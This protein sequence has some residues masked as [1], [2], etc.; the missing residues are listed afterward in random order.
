MRYL[1]Y[2]WD[3]LWLGITLICVIGALTL[4]LAYLLNG[5]YQGESGSYQTATSPSFVQQQQVNTVN[6]TAIVCG[7]PCSCAPVVRTIPRGETVTILETA[8]CSGDTWYRINV[9]EWI[10]PNLIETGNIH[11]TG[12]AAAKVEIIRPTPTNRPPTPTSEPI[13]SVADCAGGCTEY[14][15]WCAPPIKGNVSYDTGERIYHVP[16]QEYYNETKINPAYG[17]R[18]FCT[19]QEAQAAGWRKSRR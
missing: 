7:N 2:A 6:R 16:G 19:E 12:P 18:W 5:N 11:T 9:S 13:L 8:T 3:L 4:F 1:L 17:E 10:G 15:D 14:P